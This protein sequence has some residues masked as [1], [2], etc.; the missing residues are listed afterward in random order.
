ML[1]LDVLDKLYKDFECGKREVNKFRFTGVDVER[2]ENGDIQINQ[3][4]YAKSIKTIKI[5][6][7]LSNEEPLTKSQYKEFRGVIG[8]LMWISEQTRPDIAYVT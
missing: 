5:D 7:E 3:N 8:K 1:N 6:K 2:N 4:D